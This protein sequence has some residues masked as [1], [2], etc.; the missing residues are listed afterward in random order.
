MK[1]PVDAPKGKV[2]KT[3]EDLGFYVVKEKEMHQILFF[4]DQVR[5]F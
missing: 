5:N 2:I 4:F 1:F 3:F